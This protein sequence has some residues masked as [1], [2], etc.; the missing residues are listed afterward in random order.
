[1]NNDI[2]IDPEAIKKLPDNSITDVETIRQISLYGSKYRDI[3]LY[4]KIK[5]EFQYVGLYPYVMQNFLL[6]D[7]TKR[8]EI[9]KTGI[10][11]TLKE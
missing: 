11:S 10:E 3:S 7:E 6:Y 5:K 2:T 4:P 9:T 1:M 8:S